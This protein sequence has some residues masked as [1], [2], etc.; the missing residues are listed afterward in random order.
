MA[1]IFSGFAWL[2]VL[3]M[4]FP[5]M[6]EDREWMPLN[7]LM[8]H[9][10]LDKFYAAPLSQRDKVRARGVLI[11]SN[12][13]IK[14]S[15]VVLT[16]AH[17][18][19]KERIALNPDGSFELNPSAK[20]IQENPMVLTSMPAGEKGGLGI[21]MFAALTPNAT[22]FSYVDLLG[23]V[24]QAN[25]LIKAQAGMLSLFVPKMNG[26]LVRFAKGGTPVLKIAAK[27]GVTTL[28]ADAAG[29]IAVKIDEAWMSEN[30]QITASQPVLEAEIDALK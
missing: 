29:V 20:A 9:I 11:P 21:N 3:L 18:S 4:C 8:G 15:D 22:Q 13:A 23:G 30:P 5:A 7:K 28:T 6:A 27:S 16:I 2:T 14:P 12:K 26:V 19:G 24:T 17:A 1:R 10:Y 25:A